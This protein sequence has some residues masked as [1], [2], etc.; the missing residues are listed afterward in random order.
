[1]PGNQA[2]NATRIASLLI[3]ALLGALTAASLHAQPPQQTRG[4]ENFGLRGPVHLVVETSK[5][6]N[7]DPRKDR[8]LSS[9]DTTGW[10]EFDEHGSFLAQGQDPAELSEVPRN[11]YVYDA[12]GR[13]VEMGSWSWDHSTLIRQVYKYGPF[14][15]AEVSWYSGDTFTGR[16]IVEYDQ[17]GN[18]V[19]DKSYDAEGRLTHQSIE[20]YDPQSAVLDTQ[21]LDAEGQSQI[22]VTDSDNP[23]SAIV[24]HNTLD[25][26]GRVV[27]TLRLYKGQLHSWWLSPDFKCA[28]GQSELGI[29]NWE[30]AE[31]RFQT[32]FT[33]RCPRTLEI[34]VLHHAGKTGNLENDYEERRSEDG[35]I[36][37]RIEFEYTRDAQ[38]NWTERLMKVWDARTTDMIP[39]KVDFRNIIYYSAEK[40]R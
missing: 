27:S 12:Q 6:L 19:G 10:L 13:F 11:L 17:Q 21:G 35:T 23:K 5:E 20:K 1:M 40:S 3:T 38:G 31:L 32:Y 8:H 34:T 36:L 15:P 4:S 28:E 33:L 16:T 14:G 37:E 22:H 7:P 9:N 29:F 2:E 24:E 25:E 39:V 18:P 30:E 26:N